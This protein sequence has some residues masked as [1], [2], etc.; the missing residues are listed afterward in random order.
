MTDR[1]SAPEVTLRYF[2]WLRERAGVSEERLR[3]PADIVTVRDLLLWQARRGQP[4]DRAFAKPEAIRVAIDHAHVKP[5]A[6][7]GNAREIAFF[8]PV[9]GG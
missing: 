6:A 5:T 1:Q 4:F 7:V 3:L 8:P 2:A 9:T